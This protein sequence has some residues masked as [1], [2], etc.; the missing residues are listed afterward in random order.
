MLSAQKNRKIFVVGRNKTGTTSVG[1][2]LSSLGFRLGDQSEA[3]LLMEDWAKRSFNNIAEYCRT[4]DAFQDVPFNLDYTC[5]IMDYSF[6]DSKFILTVRNSPQEWYESLT[7][8]HTMILGKNR[9][10]T[11]DDLKQFPYRRTGWLWRAH[12]LVY[13]IDE[14]TLY[15]K[16]LYIRHYEAHNQRVL[17]YFRHRPEDLLVLNLSNPESMRSLCEFLDIPVTDQV[18]PHLNRSKT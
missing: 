13:G 5:Q 18:M 15:N 10:P 16:E 7:R 11:A 3:E 14:H 4:A 17:D 8:F 2:A 1:Q 12:Q 9:L 6:P